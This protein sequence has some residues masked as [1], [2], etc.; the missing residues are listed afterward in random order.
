MK[1]KKWFSLRLACLTVGPFMVSSSVS[2][3]SGADF[4][5]TV[6]WGCLSFLLILNVLAAD[7]YERNT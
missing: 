1:R 2:F 7:F 5:W 6:F 4:N 3:L